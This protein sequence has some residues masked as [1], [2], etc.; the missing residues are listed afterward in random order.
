M[1]LSPWVAFISYHQI[2]KSHDD[3]YCSTQIYI[4]KSS[5]VFKKPKFY[6]VF[7]IS[8]SNSVF[9]VKSKPSS[10]IL[11]FTILRGPDEFVR[12]YFL[13]IQI[14]VK[15]RTLAAAVLYNVVSRHEVIFHVGKIFD[16]SNKLYRQ[17]RWQ[18]RYGDLGPA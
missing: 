3:L 5:T 14:F 1:V 8:L 9:S 6:S 13:R 10:K 17:T 16:G 7:A 18:A 4:Q 2:K 15:D 12:N 11:K